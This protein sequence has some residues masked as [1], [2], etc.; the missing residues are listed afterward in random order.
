MA[1]Y[2]NII[3]LHFDV[4][5]CFYVVITDNLLL[6]IMMIVFLPLNSDKNYYEINT[7]CPKLH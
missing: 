2:Y 5:T 4:T 6:A 7:D 1:I 3:M